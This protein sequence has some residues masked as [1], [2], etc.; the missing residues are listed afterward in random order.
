MV[1]DDP[2]LR[3]FVSEV[4]RTRGYRVIPAADGEAAL[5]TFEREGRAIDA[6]ITDV[7]MP[8]LSGRALAE[9]ML[10]VWPD[11]P[12]VFMSGYAGE[13]IGALG[14][15]LGV[16]LAFVQK[17]FAP[18]VMLARLREVLDARGVAAA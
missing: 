5:A 8:L 7:V 1:D 4:L 9:R 15:L 12:V 11:L 18:D 2:A 13:N 14:T 6:L 3:G 17:P 10:A 16:R